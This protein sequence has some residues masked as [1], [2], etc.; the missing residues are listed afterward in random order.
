MNLHIFTYTFLVGIMLTEFAE[1]P[2]NN[3]HSL[4]GRGRC[5]WS[6]A[7]VVPHTSD[8]LGTLSPDKHLSGAF[9]CKHSTVLKKGKANMSHVKATLWALIILPIDR[10]GMLLYAL[11]V[12]LGYKL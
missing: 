9:I 10:D 12:V 1:T 6:D 7:Q 5:L 3:N 4:F 2:N 8:N 11:A